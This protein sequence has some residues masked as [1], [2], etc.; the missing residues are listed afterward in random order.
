MAPPLLSALLLSLAVQAAEPAAPVETLSIVL[1]CES[2]AIPE[3]PDHTK[4]SPGRTDSGAAR[5]GYCGT[6]FKKRFV[7]AWSRDT[8]GDAAAPL[9]VN[10]LRVT[11]KLAQ[12]GLAVSSDYPA[13]DDPAPKPHEEGCPYARV[14]EHER[15]HARAYQEIVKAQC[16]ALERDLRAM[17]SSGTIPT[18]GQPWTV[19][20]EEFE[21]KKAAVAQAVKDAVQKRRQTMLD[22]SAQDRSFKDSPA[23][24]CALYKSCDAWT[25]G[26]SLDA[27]RKPDLAS[28]P[29][30]AESCL[31]P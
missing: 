11:F 6:T 29:A 14:L 16:S 22:C 24:Y 23:S 31:K 25:W 7:L 9:H 2:A 30:M 19:A 1:D 26:T 13:T 12:I 3:Q 17:A 15:S 27:C 21:A 28:A 20:P 10:T 8:A 5:G 4:E 18:A